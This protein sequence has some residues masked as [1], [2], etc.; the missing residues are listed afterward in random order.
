M[1]PASV[2]R[3]P[4]PRGLRIALVVVALLYFLGLLKHP[5]QKSLLKPLAYFTE[6]T[7]LFPE[8]DEYALEYRLE[9]WSCSARAWQPLDPRAYFPMEADDKESRFQRIGYFY[10]SNRTV[11]TALDEYI[12]A[13]HTGADDGVTGT[14]G[15]IRIYSVH[16]P[17][18]QL[19]DDVPR[20]VYEPIAPVPLDWRY[21]KPDYKNK[22]HLDYSFFHTKRSVREKRCGESI[23]PDEAD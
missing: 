19:G 18:P 9:A 1:P 14:I 12:V 2:A 23:Q 4:G 21:P 6:C 8:V 7:K 11:M 17:L 15:G 5:P 3:G 16:R 13:H 20:Y 22:I 10:N